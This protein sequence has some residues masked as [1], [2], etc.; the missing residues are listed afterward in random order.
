MPTDWIVIYG[1]IITPTLVVAVFFWRADRRERRGAQAG[2]RPQE[3]DVRVN[4]GFHPARVVLREGRPIQLRFT[5]TNDGESWW[6][7]V[8]FPYG[9][10]RRELQEGET[11]TLDVGALEEGEYAFFSALG[12]MRGALVIEPRLS[13]EASKGGV[14]GPIEA[15]VAR[16]HGRSA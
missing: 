14:T 12:T 3:V 4:G 7:D 6:D 15:P 5:R 16:R 1:A 2:L 11:V 13:G 10:L 8:E 9:R